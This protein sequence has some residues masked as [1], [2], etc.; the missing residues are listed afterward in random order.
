MS[1]ILIAY[2][3]TE[4]QTAKIANALARTLR[5]QGDSVDVVDAADGR[6]PDDYGAVI[7]AASVH[8]GRY[9][10]SVRRWVQGHAF[11]L[12]GKP[13]AFVS[14]SLGIL[15]KD[16][17]VQGEVAAIVDRFLLATNWMPTMR[18]SVAGALVYTQYGCVKR[19]VMRRIARRAGGDTDT[20]RDFEYTDWQ[21]VEAFAQDFSRCVHQALLRT[22]NNRNWSP[23]MQEAVPADR[24]P[25][26][27]GSSTSRRG[28][29]W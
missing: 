6:N 3:T 21:Q 18:T 19:W 26:Q 27:S 10:K 13:S 14:V 16:P 9:Q 12:R 17:K 2:G 8:G 25:D 15:Q 1:R 11:Q 4:G 20:T 24:I 29:A 23:G 5:A 22:S 7:V 28:A